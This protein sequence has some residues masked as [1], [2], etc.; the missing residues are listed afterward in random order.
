MIKSP[1]LCSG[2]FF[3][4]GR[5]SQ[6]FAPVRREPPF[7]QERGKRRPGER[8]SFP[9]TPFSG[10]SNPAFLYRK[11]G[12]G[13]PPAG[14]QGRGRKPALMRAQLV[15]TPLPALD[16]RAQTS[17]FLGT[18]PLCCTN[19]NRVQGRALVLFP[20]AF[21]RESRVPP[22]AHE[23]RHRNKKPS[24]RTDGGFHSVSTMV[25]ALPWAMA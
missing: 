22:K 2:G 23:K 20:P 3:R 16:Y 8:V 21:S 6:R 4:F 19:L 25:M 11:A 10:C 9:W 1:L 14:A 24:I 13:A 17:F 12:H 15:G 18:S 7:F 5:P